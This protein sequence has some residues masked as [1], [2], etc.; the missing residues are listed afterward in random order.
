MDL[1]ENIFGILLG[2]ISPEELLSQRLYSF[3]FWPYHM[4][5]GILI[6]Q[7][8]IEPRPLQWEHRVL[9]TGPAGK[10]PELYSY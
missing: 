7:S 4:A 9:T 5:C 3:F 2:Y 6:P 8:G 10:S 1:H